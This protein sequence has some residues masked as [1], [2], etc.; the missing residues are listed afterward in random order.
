MGVL[1][2]LIG[3]VVVLVGIAIVGHGLWLA[4]AAIFGAASEPAS[5]DRCPACANKLNPGQ[6]RC[7]KCGFTISTAHQTTLNDELA[8]TRRQ[9][10]RLRK[11]NKISA[12][13]WEQVSEALRDDARER[14][15]GFVPP[16]EEL[17]IVELA[18]EAEPA[19]SPVAAIT[20]SSV[21]SPA[22][23]F[24]AAS[25]VE[26][27][28]VPAE[29]PQFAPVESLLQ[30]HEER[31]PW[32]G[33]LQA[34]MEEK[35][36]RW[37]ELVSGLLIV[38]SSVGLVISLW[39]TLE[40]A[41]PYFPVAVF[42]TATA[43]MHGAGLYT[44]R[45]WRLR[46]TSRGLLLMSTL[47]VPLNVLAAMVLNDKNPAYGTIDY[48]AFAIGLS[49]LSAIAVSAARVLNRR[50]PWPTVIAV[51]GTA[52]GMSTIGR[53]ARPG[54]DL[55][56][57]LGLFALP[58]FS[59][60]VAT[61]A[62]IVSLSE[63]RRLTV[64]RVAQ[65]F[66]FFGIAAFGLVLAG[67]LL[68][69][70]CGDIRETLTLLSPMLAAVAATLTGAGLIVHQRLADP[71]QASFRLAGTS[72]ALGGGVLAAAALALAWPR[73]DLL[74]A[75]GLLDAV[76]F[77][78]LAWFAAFPALNVI[79]TAS[80]SLAFLVGYE[81]ASG[82]ISVL[83]ATTELLMAVLL[84]AR[85]ALI[86]CLLSLAI[87]VAGCFL[88]RL[89]SRPSA[90]SYFTSALVHEAVSVAIAVW[91]V[92]KDV[93][94]QDLTTVVFALLA[95]RW[96]VS[97]WWIKRPYAS[98]IAATLLFGAVA[99]GL[100][101][102][103]SVA[104]ALAARSL[105]PTDPWK[106]S[107]LVHATL[108]LG[109]AAAARR[110]G[111]GLLASPEERD[112]SLVAP[113]T[114]AAI[115]TSALAVPM[116]LDL[117]NEHF[118]THG[119]Y[120]LWAS[121]I[122]F[123]VALLQGS[124][125][126]AVASQV[127]ATIGVAV[128]VTGICNRQ[129]WWTGRFSDPLFLNW[130]FGALA[131]WSCLWIAA[132][133]VGQRVTAFARILK[134]EPT[135]FDRILLGGVAAGLVAT[136]LVAT[137]PGI[138]AELASIT[139][140]AIGRPYVGAVLIPFGVGA[141]L[142]TAHAIFGR[143]WQKTA[144][145]VVVLCVFG[146]MILSTPMYGQ[147]SIW[148]GLP[149]RYGQG[150]G[151]G[152]WIALA[153]ALVA[154][155]AAHWERPNRATL[156][157]IALLLSA[158][159]FLVACRWDAD[160]RTA[161][162]LRWTSAVAGLAVAAIWGACRMS[163]PI[164]PRPDGDHSE[165]A[166]RQLDSLRNT[167]IAATSL[168][169]LILTCQSLVDVLGAGRIVPTQSHVLISPYLSYTVP[170]GILAAAFVV[171]AVTD[172]R[173]IWGL[174]AT[175]LVQIAIG[176]AAGLSLMLSNQLQP[177]A[178]VTCFL[179]EM[180]LLNV[181]AAAVW[182]GIEA[183]AQR[184]SVGSVEPLSALRTPI[185]TQLGFLGVIVGLL[186]VGA[187]IG[188]WLRPELLYDAVRE[189][190]GP[191][192]WLLIISATLIWV[193]DRRKNWPLSAVEVGLLL[194][195]AAAVFGAASLGPWNSAGNWLSFHTAM[196]GWCAVFGLAAFATLMTRS[197]EHRGGAVALADRALILLPVVLAFAFK[198]EALD[199][200]RPW[201]GAGAI[202]WLSLC[203][204]AM[205][206]GAESRLRSYLSFLL[207]G[208]GAALIGARPW[209]WVER[210]FSGQPIVDLADILILG[211]GLHGLIWL[212]IE[213]THERRRE[214]PFDEPSSL[215]PVHHY[216]VTIGTFLLG[217]ATL[218]V[219]A[220][221]ARLPY[222]SSATP[223]AWA[224]LV[225]IAALAAG[226]LWERRAEHPFP[227]LYALGLIA[228]AKLL[229]WRQLDSRYL[230]FAAAT[231][232]AGYIVLSGAMW[233]VR[234]PMKEFGR[235]IGMTP[236]A[237]DRE[238]VIPWLGP[239]S[240][241]IGALVIGV[242]CWV[243]LTFNET[244]LRIAGALATLAVGGGLALLT[245]TRAREILQ[246]IALGVVAIAAVQFG[247]SL[248]S[249]IGTLPHEELRRAI[250]MMAM[251][252]ATTFVYGL[253]LVRLVAP[254]SSWFASIRR[255][256]IG[257]AV[258]TI[259]IL[260]LVLLF[261]ISTFD[262]TGG[263]PVTV[264]E[265]LLVASALALL[266]AG[267]ICLAVLP[268]RDPF[269]QVERQRFLY[270]YAAEVVCALL[271][272]HIY[273]TNP[274]FFR[275]RLQPYWPL[276]VMA[277]AYAGVAVSELFRRLKISV[278]SEP[279]EYSA[280]FLPVLPVVGFWFM[281]SE[282]SYST[283]LVVIG[284]LYVFLSL[285]RGSFV[286]PAAAAVVGNATLCSLL[287]DHGVSLLFHPQMF[288]ISPCLT[289]LAAAQ[290][291]RDRLD[292][293][294]LASLRYFAMTAIYVSSTGEMFQHGI[295]TTLWLPMVLAGLSVFGVLAGIVLRVRAFLYLGTSFLLL[296]IVSM[297]WHAARSI[298]HVW[299]WWVFLFALGVGLLTLFGV[300]EK[301]RP[302][303]LA[304]V[305]SLREWER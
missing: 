23:R 146:T 123:A 166:P 143:Q 284:L 208:L 94:D 13:T 174:A 152:A 51:V 120:A 278:L 262:P 107:L 79:A 220:N 227:I 264:G 242:E 192:G 64:R 206:V 121:T 266:A 173:P 60:L 259:S 119:V 230:I 155:T 52:I 226:S 297:V 296:S 164:A 6:S 85:S 207:A 289:V 80:F 88:V 14:E 86:L 25:L 37:G 108:C 91:A 176:F 260:A 219:L 47:L 10:E 283:V 267:L 258:T 45:R 194:F 153:L 255:A 7:L 109:C 78:A 199:P 302:E 287:Y 216:A 128:G 93:P 98:W 38:G 162:A 234:R 168:P 172:R 202:I 39:A 29:G 42:L 225:V 245:T 279:L 263:T 55:G 147:G 183:F 81:W 193:W 4:G 62:H 83:G 11:A 261:E 99:H 27:S 292:A 132:R 9:L 276:I 272:A 178:V 59:F 293:R 179:Q 115:A 148:P 251:L 209:L 239:A 285:R 200:L 53:L 61:I 103:D 248:M 201:W 30:P 215:H 198:A 36:I 21:P 100:A 1:C 210:P 8:A 277:I 280:A 184:R 149:S 77:T 2:G 238:R 185:V 156:A 24:F 110:S 246:R 257:V 295:G 232:L 300:F 89:K 151:G 217:L 253:P 141:V 102:N 18:D 133:R 122:W 229:G 290:I 74:V 46:S 75:V 268:G 254:E 222:L 265:S 140:R 40:K 301:K 273:L 252:G 218:L 76:A 182:C 196:A 195:S 236:F 274:E 190:G 204:V 134:C 72:I 130:Q 137:W 66:R 105:Y 270:V 203:V 125:G 154:V 271:C 96:L 145:F 33:F 3:L 163:I 291:N 20:S 231:S 224:G 84:T 95:A 127:L 117:T 56:R 286:Y 5:L 159:P 288:V 136:C 87:D 114:G 69:Y 180:G 26:P 181:I 241:V 16:T 34:F 101:M 243:V 65:S 90:I 170:L 298:G 235:R 237:T 43:A 249:P 71:E 41:I 112:Q 250:R 281:G 228:I 157:G 22:E 35:N 28:A 150:W 68:A 221:Q 177:A 48:V 158:I 223:L 58:F 111:R 244:S 49:V 256:A 139:S 92:W 299:P 19:Q 186:T 214:R 138:V 275:H 131:V 304:L 189:C 212:V 31:R 188:L 104:Q 160:L 116:V 305:G 54:A 118:L 205:A 191:L 247:W 67:G 12:A 135:S 113:F 50:N 171:Y 282:L 197:A 294:S 211:M 165:S 169:V 106:M 129:L 63:G 240:L 124:E 233:T 57:T 44:L 32:G 175:F 142:A 269:F 144:A 17:E 82:A 187:T 73:P 161:T 97:A 126:L 167:L 15:I 70:K 213:I 303:V